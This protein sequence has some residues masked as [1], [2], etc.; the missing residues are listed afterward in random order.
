MVKLYILVV[1]WIHVVKRGANRWTAVP[2][3]KMS[4]DLVVGCDC[5]NARLVGTGE[6]IDFVTKE[7]NLKTIFS[8]HAYSICVCVCVC[9]NV[10][11]IPDSSMVLL[12]SI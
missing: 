4:Q 11:A 5:F 3:S 12:S 10:I 2:I 9:F 7:E 1:V 8:C 6:S